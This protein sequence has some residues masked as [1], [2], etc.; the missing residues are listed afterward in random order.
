MFK[1]M[2]T[3]YWRKFTGARTT[4]IEILLFLIFV[5]VPPICVF[6]IFGIFDERLFSISFMGIWYVFAFFYPQMCKYLINK[7]KE[8]A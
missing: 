4:Y 6:V 1:K 2:F 3:W 5:F 7:E 8:N